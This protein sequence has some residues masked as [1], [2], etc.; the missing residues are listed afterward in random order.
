MICLYL[1]RR[2]KRS[3]IWAN[4]HWKL[5]SVAIGIITTIYIPEIFNINLTVYLIMYLQMLGRQ[6]TIIGFTNLD[7]FQLKCFQ[8]NI[9]ILNFN[10][11]KFIIST[12][13]RNLSRL[14]RASNLVIWTKVPE[15][16]SNNWFHYAFDGQLMQCETLLLTNRHF[17]A[18]AE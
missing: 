12:S 15:T 5:V 1:Y 8:K 18:T 14:L 2:P 4:H 7:V 9:K 17:D 11:R 3:L 13:H 10:Y 6:L 16:L